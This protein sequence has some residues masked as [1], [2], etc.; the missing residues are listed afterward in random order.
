VAGTQAVVGK[1]SRIE[2]EAGCEAIS[3]YSC[4]LDVKVTQPGSFDAYVPLGCSGWGW[5]PS[6]Q[7]VCNTKYQLRASLLSPRCKDVVRL[8]FGAWSC[9]L[10]GKGLRDAATQADIS[11]GTQTMLCITDS[12]FMMFQAGL[13]VLAANLA[14]YA[15]YHSAQFSEL[16]VP[17]F[18]DEYPYGQFDAQE[19]SDLGHFCKP[20]VPNECIARTFCQARV[21]AT[22]FGSW[23]AVRGIN[24]PIFDLNSRRPVDYYDGVSFILLR[25]R[26][27][28]NHLLYYMF[29][30]CLR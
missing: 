4:D 24:D 7:S 20:I 9:L 16:S 14:S 25:I 22:C 11:F 5:A 21:L 12:P 3:D 18:D 17:A 8:C 13:T 10:G 27:I 30:L 15:K 23:F 2:D 26:Y 19:S 28:M 6:P 1:H 29:V